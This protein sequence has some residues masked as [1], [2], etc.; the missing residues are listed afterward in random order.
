MKMRARIRAELDEILSG[1]DLVMT[2][3]AP[4]TALPFDFVPSNL[5]EE[6]YG[7]MFTVIANLSGNPALS[8]PIKTDEKLSAGLQLIGKRFDEKTLYS[9]GVA[10]EEAQK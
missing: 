8:V 10:I 2:P 3:T 9:A 4:T 1:R 7:D 5:Y 6:Y